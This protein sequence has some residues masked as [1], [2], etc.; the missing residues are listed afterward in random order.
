MGRDAN[1]IGLFPNWV[2]IEKYRPVDASALRAELGLAPGQ[3]VAL[4][5]GAMGEKQ[6]VE[7]LL[8]VARLLEA[9][10]D[11]RVVLCGAGPARARIEA[12]LAGHPNVLL[13]DPQPEDRFLQL[14]SMA[15]CHL[16]PQKRGVTHFVMPSKLG[17]MLA[18]GKPIVAQAEDD[19]EVA[20]ALG[21]RHQRRAA[22]GV[23]AHG[24]GGPGHGGTRAAAVSTRRRVTR[25]RAKQPSCMR[26]AASPAL[27]GR[28]IP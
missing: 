15:D 7:S 4:Y 19:C 25:R 5:A 23:G 11:I 9:A 1:R 22:G 12:R 26:S 13:L 3:F 18:S 28:P 2:D 24:R 14:L 17:P 6:G 16:L 10:P 8:D 21:G 27:A 20:R